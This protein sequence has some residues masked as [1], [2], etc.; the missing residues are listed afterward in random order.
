METKKVTGETT[1]RMQAVI[2]IPVIH[3]RS[4]EISGPSI[5]NMATSKKKA[6]KE[7]IIENLEIFLNILAARL[8]PN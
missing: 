3:A 5:T 4:G 1:N 7:A 8:G 2:A 6:D